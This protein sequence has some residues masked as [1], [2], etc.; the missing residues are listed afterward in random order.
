MSS[1][2]E[3]SEDDNQ[4][5]GILPSSQNKKCIDINF[6]IQEINLLEIPNKNDSKE[7]FFRLMTRTNCEVS[8]QENKAIC[9]NIVNYIEYL[10]QK[11]HY[12]F[13]DKLYDETHN[14]L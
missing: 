7:N 4:F 2:T 1:Y 10:K 14:P 5:S 11:E 6:D 8:P 12:L 3:D 13:Q 9:V